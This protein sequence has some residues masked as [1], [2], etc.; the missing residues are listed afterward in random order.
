L[1]KLGFIVFELVVVLLQGFVELHHAVYV[2][3][4][5]IEGL[6][7]LIDTLLGPGLRL[8]ELD[9]Q[10]AFH[11]SKLVVKLRPLRLILLL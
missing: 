5:F 9:L 2:A 11:L 1:L 4:L 3:L 7:H 8:S 10:T 6:L